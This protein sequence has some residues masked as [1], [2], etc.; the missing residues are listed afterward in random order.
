[1]ADLKATVKAAFKERYGTGPSHIAHAPGRVNIIGEHTD[2]NEGFVLPAAMDKAIYIAAK[3]RND[4]TVN[5]KSLDYNGEASFTLGQLKEASLPDWTSYPRGALWV[6]KDKG[7]KLQG[8]DLL[9]SGNVPLGGGFSSSAAIEVA[10]FET[11]AALFDIELTQTQKALLGVEVEHRFIGMPSGAMDQLASALGKADHALLIDCR[12]NEATPIPVPSGVTLLALDTGKRRELLNSE[13]AVRRQQCEEA[14]KLLGVKA[15]R[16]VTPEQL[17]ANV[18]KLPEI[19][20]RRAAHVVNEDV[21]TLAAVE[22]FKA[23]DL[24]TVGRLINESHV[25]LRDLFEVSITELDIMAELAQKEE[26]CYGARMMGGGFG[27]AVIA[28]VDDGAVASITAHVGEA[29]TAATHLK[30]F[31]YPV[32]AGAGSGVEKA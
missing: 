18:D 16:D 29:Y 21:R 5:I 10:M 23:G 28:L 22:A 4:D 30:A 1:M 17:A 27:G 2:Y 31:I 14:A 15:L 12:T 20:E 8:M 6:L 24:K 3:A 19:I 13:Y 25:S 26:G 32:K 7:H 11:A 9:I